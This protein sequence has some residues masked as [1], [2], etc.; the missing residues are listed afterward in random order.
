[1]EPHLLFTITGFISSFIA[2]LLNAILLFIM[3]C[4]RSFKAQR[5][6]IF[7][8]NLSRTILSIIICMFWVAWHTFYGRAI[9]KAIFK[10]Q[11]SIYWIYAVNCLL[12]TLD[13]L[14]E[15]AF[16]VKYKT[17]PIGIV[18]KISIAITASIGITTAVLFASFSNDSMYQGYFTLV[19][20]TLCFV[21]HPGAYYIINNRQNNR[22]NL[23]RHIG[24]FKAF[25]RSDTKII[26]IGSIMALCSML[27]CIADI[28]MIF[29]QMKLPASKTRVPVGI[30]MFFSTILYILQPVVCALLAFDFSFRHGKRGWYDRSQSW[31]FL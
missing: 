4:E 2:F 27:T 30:L 15:V 26:R 17:M 5:F 18:H 7:G 31:R 24:V 8:I 25:Q 3:W 29:I 20:D 12:F 16:P 22:N 1:M 10:I 21:T 9:E 28:A 13:R 23:A 19:L 11:R 14:F 6:L